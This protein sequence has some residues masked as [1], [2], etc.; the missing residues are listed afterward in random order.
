MMAGSVASAVIAGAPDITMITLTELAE[1]SRRI[2]RTSDISLIVDADH[3][4]GNALNVMRTVQELENANVS[5]LTIEDTLLPQTFGNQ[6]DSLISINEATGKFRAALH[7][8]TDPS[9]VIIGRT[10]AMETEGITGTVKR[11]QAYSATGIDALFFTKITTLEQLEAIHASTKL[12]IFL[13]SAPAILR[14]PALLARNGVRISIQG[15]LPF[16]NMVLELYNSIRQ[17]THLD[18]TANAPTLSQAEIIATTLSSE[19]YT[20]WQRTFMQ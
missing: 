1:Q 2:T 19:E 16:Q 17:Q 5:A 14:D 12:P 3:G 4:Y 13:G 9:T 18:E 7:A 20:V 8:R 10:S 15:H 6:G 11:S